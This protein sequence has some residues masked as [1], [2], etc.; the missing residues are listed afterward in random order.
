MIFIKKIQRFKGW[1]LL[2][3]AW[4]QT[5]DKVEKPIFYFKYYE[6]WDL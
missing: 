2:L 4:L 1:K 3:R 6:V 5:S